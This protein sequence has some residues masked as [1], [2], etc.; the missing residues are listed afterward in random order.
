MKPYYDVAITKHDG[1]RPILERF[2]TRLA[3]RDF[4]KPLRGKRQH[5]EY[6]EVCI[7]KVVQRYRFA[8]APKPKPEG[9]ELSGLNRFISNVAKVFTPAP[10]PAEPKPT[11]PPKPPKATAARKAKASSSFA[12][13]VAAAQKPEGSYSESSD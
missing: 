10:A 8:P 5:P 6:A 12:S 7:Q 4:I 13:R 1:S 11:E 9:K 3:M 2:R